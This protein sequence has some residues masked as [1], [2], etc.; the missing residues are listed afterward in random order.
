MCL[1]IVI[2]V[3]LTSAGACQQEW[4]GELPPPDEVGAAPLP[5]GAVI[6]GID[7]VHAR[8]TGPGEAGASCH[9]LVRLQ[10]DGTA[11]YQTQCSDQPITAVAA[12]PA[13]W[14]R[15]RGVGD[16]AVVG[17]T[18]RVRTVEWDSITEEYVLVQQELPACAAEEYV[19]GALPPCG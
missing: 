7:A 3:V 14:E 6:G 10:A 5:A 9:V 16:Y 18:V 4:D 11:E 8:L 1:A 13:T 15:P 12:D 17:A 19:M 2:G